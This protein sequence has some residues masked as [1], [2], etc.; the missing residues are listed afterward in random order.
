MNVRQTLLN[1]AEDSEF[2]VVGQSR[3]IRR[4]F[5]VNLDVA[6]FRKPV[7]V[8]AHSGNQTG[9]FKQG[10][11]KKMRQG[12]NFIGSLLYQCRIL[13]H[14]SG[15]EAIQ[16]MGL[17]LY[18]SNI[19]TKGSH[20]LAYAVVQFASQAPAL[21]ILHFEQAGREVPQAFICSL[22]FRGPFPHSN[23]QMIAGLA[24]RAQ[25]LTLL[26]D[27][28]VCAEPAGDFAL[29]ISKRTDSG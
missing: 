2:R 7:H 8:P 1:D 20:N 28:S 12:S 16:L 23:F 19:H 27:V 3:E 24:E 6:A 11:M 5:Q 10:R 29:R 17:R 26:I 18:D 15:S 9:D 25:Q 22:K 21:V 14:S 13:L 4:D